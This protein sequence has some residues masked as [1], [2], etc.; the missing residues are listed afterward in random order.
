MA[1]PEFKHHWADRLRAISAER[2]FSVAELIRISIDSFLERERAK[3]AATSG[4]VPWRQPAG[5]RLR[6]RR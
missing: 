5:L 3:A 6:P 4:L 2:H 1:W